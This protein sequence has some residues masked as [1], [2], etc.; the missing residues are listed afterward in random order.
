MTFIELIWTFRGDRNFFRF[1]FLMIRSFFFRM[2]F[3]FHDVLQVKA[4]F[5]SNMNEKE[6]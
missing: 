2:H 5:I 3:P 6:K 4:A 1:L